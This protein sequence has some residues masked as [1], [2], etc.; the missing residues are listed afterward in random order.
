MNGNGSLLIMV[1]IATTGC[2]SAIAD[3]ADG[4]ALDDVGADTDTDTGA[5]NGADSDSDVATEA[6]AHDGTDVEN[7]DASDGSPVCGN[8]VREGL[9]ECDDGN[10]V[11]RDGCESDC[12]FSCHASADCDDRNVCT[13]D[14]CTTVE[15]G[16]LCTY[17][18]ATVACD[19]SDACTHGDFCEGGLCRAGRCTSAC[20]W[21]RD[22]DG[23]GYGDVPPP[24]PACSVTRPAA[25]WVND[26]TDC[27]DEQA[28][29]NPAQMGF[30]AGSYACG[31]VGATYWDYNCDGRDELRFASCA[32]C[33]GSSYATCALAAEGW[34][35]TVDSEGST[36]CAPPAC[37]VSGAW[38]TACAWITGPSGEA[39]CNPVPDPVSLTVQECR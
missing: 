36:I 25:G 27:C 39:G 18:D 2:G 21:A 14:S 19:D 8:R 12:R 17:A 29:A 38:V 13:T 15:A 34:L 3:E 22:V 7:V 9:E 23:D 1:L 26:T 10:A 4:D 5:D 32:R 6:D 20:T 16:R 31:V 24:E 37:G 30:F 35:P 28:N 33:A 11:P